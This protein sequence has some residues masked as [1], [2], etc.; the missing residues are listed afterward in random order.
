MVLW[1]CVSSSRHLLLV[2]I[3][4]QMDDVK[5]RG[6]LHENLLQSANKTKQTKKL[7]V[8][9]NFTFQQDSTPKVVIPQD[10]SNTGWLGE[11]SRVTKCRSEST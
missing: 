3:E 7:K 6:M 8:E 10:Q 1:G 5:Y 2:K 4:G 11:Y 9:G